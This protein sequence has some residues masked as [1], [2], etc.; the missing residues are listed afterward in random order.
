MTCPR[1]ERTTGADGTQQTSGQAVLVGILEEDKRE[2][3]LSLPPPP[4]RGRTVP[5][6]AA[7]FPGLSGR[8]CSPAMHVCAAVTQE[9]LKYQKGD[10]RGL[11]GNYL[12][13]LSP[14]GNNSE[15]RAT[16]SAEAPVG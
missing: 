6:H 13:F 3:S 9:G 2:R 1:E 5:A 4:P 14:S 8:G 10:Q 7:D 11:T 12:G 16:K 15:A